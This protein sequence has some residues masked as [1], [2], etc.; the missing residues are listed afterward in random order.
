MHYNYYAALN[1]PLSL[2][3][4]HSSMYMVEVKLS[5]HIFR[6]GFMFCVTFPAWAF[7]YIFTELIFTCFTV[8][9]F[10]DNI[11]CVIFCTTGHTG[12]FVSY[13]FKKNPHSSLKASKILM[14][15]KTDAGSSYR[16]LLNAPLLNALSSYLSERQ[17][18]VKHV[19]VGYDRFYRT[20]E[21]RYLELGYLK[22]CKTRSIFLNQ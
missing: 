8:F 14:Q 7:S 9:Y 10:S 6:D 1:S 19:V 3:Q 13:N 12:E 20:V 2:Y 15:C 18:N 22:F 16:S 17:L 4:Y 5:F 11:I 21:S